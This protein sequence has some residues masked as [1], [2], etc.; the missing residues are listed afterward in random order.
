MEDNWVKSLW[1]E[2]QKAN[3]TNKNK[4]QAPIA[5]VDLDKK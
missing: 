3:E 2:V 1:E 4:E 5:E